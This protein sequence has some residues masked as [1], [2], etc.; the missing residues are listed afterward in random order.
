MRLGLLPTPSR[1]L[2]PLSTRRDVSSSDSE[3]SF[4][5]STSLRK[6]ST[7]RKRSSDAIGSTY[8]ASRAESAVSK[9]KRT[10][11]SLVEQKIATTF[12]KLPLSGKIPAEAIVVDDDSTVEERDTASESSSSDTSDDEEVSEVYLSPGPSIPSSNSPTPGPINLYHKRDE[13][14]RRIAAQLAQLPRHRHFPNNASVQTRSDS[15]SDRSTDTGRKSLLPSQYGIPK[16]EVIVE[17]SP[18]LGFAFKPHQDASPSCDEADTSSRDKVTQLPTSPLKASESSVHG[19]YNSVNR[20]SKPERP[21][22]S[23]RLS[24]QVAAIPERPPTPPLPKDGFASEA[25]TIS[26]DAKSLPKGFSMWATSAPSS[27]AK[28]L[29]KSALTQPHPGRLQSLLGSK[30][31]NFSPIPTAKGSMADLSGL[32]RMPPLA[33][34]IQFGEEAFSADRS[35]LGYRASSASPRGQLTLSQRLAVREPPQEEMPTSSAKRLSE[36]IRPREPFIAA[37][38]TRPPSPPSDQPATCIAIT[39]GS[40]SSTGLR[41]KPLP[42]PLAERMADI[43]NPIDLSA[44]AHNV[45]AAPPQ[46]SL[47]DTS[48][49]QGSGTRHCQKSE[50]EQQLFSGDDQLGDPGFVESLGRVASNDEEWDHTIKDDSREASSSLV[51]AR[52][53]VISG[54]TNGSRI[55][56]S[57]AEA[58]LG[59]RLSACHN[60]PADNA[61]VTIH[62][63]TLTV[64]SLLLQML[65][66]EFRGRSGNHQNLFA[67][68]CFVDSSSKCLQNYEVALAHGLMPFKTDV[69]H[70]IEIL[71]G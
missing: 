69:G 64:S 1:P 21:L 41:Y 18:L 13:R 42:R 19:S 27:T 44:R 54:S 24:S 20:P 43:V 23:E 55:A 12:Q 65:L 7:S 71:G 5:Q 70:L 29:V 14:D 6:G 38:P 52:A 51:N 11:S 15:D 16:T 49:D 9:R 4:H 62:A 57:Q 8:N 60:R 3:P 22:S 36:R 2:T 31:D 34:N 25:E 59:P 56:S 61:L 46:P 39:I 45:L 40:S 37:K 68:S 10:G 67:S 35:Q 30:V 32:L 26:P 63:Q 58:Q 47:L 50:Y 33:S 48:Q 66:Q 53:A 17:E 28:P